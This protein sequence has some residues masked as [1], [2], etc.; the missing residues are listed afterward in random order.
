[1]IPYLLTFFLATVFALFL[2]PVAIKLAAKWGIMDYPGERRVHERPVPRLG[3]LAI[4]LSFWLVVLLQIVYNRDFN[5]DGFRVILGLFVGSTVLFAVGIV[6]DIKGVRP[7]YKFWWQLV[8]AII[9]LL[10]GLPVPFDITLPLIGTIHF[11]F[12]G[13]LFVV[14][15]IV[16]LVNTVNISDGLDGLA[17][18]ICFFASLILFWSARQIEMVTASL[19]MLTLAGVAFGFLFFNFN[20]AKIFMGDSGSMF[21]GYIIGVVSIWGLLKTPAVIGLVIPLL[22]MGMPIVDLVFAIIR[23]KWKGLS[24]AR[25]DRGHLH[26]RL[27]DVGLTQRQAVLVLYSISIG[28]CLSAVLYECGLWYLALILVGINLVILST[29]VLRKFNLPYIGRKSKSKIGKKYYA[30]KR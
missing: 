7:R 3:G 26:H 25:A 20:P 10:F 21:L 30:Q 1:M 27:L 11:G 19:M 2:T 28:F 6:D 14:L 16:G 8:T 15:W 22:V 5:S 13:Y 18:G 24:I 4:Y 17:A 29:I 23:R 12:F 9:P